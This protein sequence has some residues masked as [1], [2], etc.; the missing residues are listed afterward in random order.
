MVVR[1]ND[2]RRARIELIRH[3]LRSTHYSGRDDDA[4]G[5]N[6]DKIIMDAPKFLKRK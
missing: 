2:K 5:K 6:D 3:I 1:S 4:I